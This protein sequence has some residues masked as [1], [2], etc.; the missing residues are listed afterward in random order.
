MPYRE[1]LLR[2]L[3]P[4][5]GPA[6]AERAYSSYL[7]DFWGSAA[8]ADFE[9]VREDPAV[10]GRFDPREAGAKRV[11]RDE[12]ARAAAGEWVRGFRAGEAGW[13][14]PGADEAAAPG[15]EGGDGGGDG[16]DGP[17]PMDADATSP[18]GS[19]PPEGRGGG[20]DAPAAAAAT[21]RAGSARAAR[22]R[23]PGAPPLAPHLAWQPDRIV[24]DLK[25]ARTIAATL[26]LEK[27]V[28]A[29]LAEQGGNPLTG[30]AAPAASAVEAARAAAAPL[31]ATPAAADP[32]L[33]DSPDAVLAALDATLAYLWDVHRVDYYGGREDWANR[34]PLPGSPEA[35]AAAADAVVAAVAAAT[36]AAAPD[37]RRGGGG[38][39]GPAD[40][41]RPRPPIR[42]TLRPP[43]AAA[44]AALAS[45]GLVGEG[46]AAAA[47][48][49]NG[50]AAPP[51]PPTPSARAA[52]DRWR[53]TYRRRIDGHWHGRLKHGD[54]LANR[55]NAAGVEAGLAAWVEAQVVKHADARWGSKLSTKL[56]VGRDFVL[57]HVRTKH[58]AALEAAR[59]RVCDDLFFEAWARA[60]EADGPPPGWGGGGGGGGPPPFPPYGPP[61]PYGMMGGGGG[62]GGPGP[63][64]PGGP[65]GPPLPR[66]GG[67]G[68][69]GGGGPP[70]R[71][72]PPPPRGGGGGGGGPPGGGRG[73]G[74]LD[75]DDPR[76]NRAVLD[77]GDL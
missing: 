37:D 41:T 33:P 43:R 31:A 4:D 55:A 21:P 32:P 34:V 9:R 12:A 51:L 73:R 58:P 65:R 59:A 64:G 16:G 53:D 68:P 45:A 74:Y 19:V 38:G 47:A 56:F 1:F 27:G 23:P 42:R 60:R 24:L 69:R 30:G 62:G 17:A 75:L 61:P 39:G 66:G 46:G 15:E 11:G 14:S 54:P 76:N 20:G 13:V 28:T 35:A 3:H 2:E 18:P 57:K 40:R 50:D 48:A 7:A 72:G 25:R 71:G 22:G 44:E 63:Y 10:R 5:V 70:V 77:Y 8:R 36:A 26:D 6:E 49:T 52:A 67:G 29:V